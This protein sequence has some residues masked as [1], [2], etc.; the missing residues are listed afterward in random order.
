MQIRTTLIT[1]C[2]TGIGYETAKGLAEAGQNLI[3]VARSQKKLTNLE[4]ELNQ[5]NNSIKIKSY[6]C[7]F[8]D[9]RQTLTVAKKIALENPDLDILLN[10]AGTWESK[11]N[12]TS[13]G[14]ELTWVVNYFAMY[15]FT[16]TLFPNLKK[17]V[18]ATKD[19]RIIILSSEAH[20]QGKFDFEN[21]FKFGFQKT[22]SDTKLADLM[23]GFQLAKRLKDSGITV[24]MIHP[25]VIAT[26]LWRK[27]PQP[28]AW[29]MSK[30][31]A[32]PVEGAKTSIYL[33]TLSEL[34][35]TGKYWAKSK[36]K[37]TTEYSLDEAIQEKLMEFTKAKVA[38]IK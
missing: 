12:L 31:L 17:R 35:E 32:S 1:G 9:L 8:A 11:L 38:G 21:I 10:N 37:A 6:L 14:L 30:V 24:N 5:L 23:Y 33:A 27:L 7:D 25:G 16:E 4:A 18:V 3:L 36:V 19:V 20:R 28:F 26:G 2:T 15:L 34:K 13:D 29:I 22:Y